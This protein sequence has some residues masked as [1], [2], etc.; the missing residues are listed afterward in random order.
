MDVSEAA[1]SLWRIQM[2][3]HPACILMMFCWT[4]YIFFPCLNESV[5]SAED[6][7]SQNVKSCYDDLSAMLYH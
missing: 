1:L 4:I 6:K 7:I 2:Y 3:A 5:V